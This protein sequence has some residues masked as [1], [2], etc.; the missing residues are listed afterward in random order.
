MDATLI[1]IDSDA[2]LA[3]AHALVDRLMHSVDPKDLALLAAQARLISA[4]EEAKWPRSRPGTAEIIRYLMDQHGLTRADLVPILGTP[5]RVSEVLRGKKELSMTMVQRLRAGV[6]VPAE[7]LLPPAEGAP[8]LDGA[9]RGLNRETAQPSVS[10]PKLL[11]L[12]GKLVEHSASL[13]IDVLLETQ[14]IFE[15]NAPVRPDQAER[16]FLRLQE[17]HGKRPRHIQKIGRLLR[18]EL[19]ITRHDGDRVARPQCLAG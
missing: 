19:G 2:E 9:A 17:S 15:P 5:S 13:P 18:G 12:R 16:A 7:L 1:V 3:R 8:P 11:S 14:N 10:H 4:Y 6:R